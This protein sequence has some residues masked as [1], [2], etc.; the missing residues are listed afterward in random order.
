MKLPTTLLFI[1]L[2]CTNCS[3]LLLEEIEIVSPEL[4]EYWGNQVLILN[5][6][7]IGIDTSFYNDL[8]LMKFVEPTHFNKNKIVTADLFFSDSLRPSFNWIQRLNYSALKKLNR[9]SR[10]SKCIC[11][12]YRFQLKEETIPIYVPED[13]TCYPTKI[14]KELTLLNGLFIFEKDTS[15]RVLYSH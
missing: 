7:T 3:V 1:T 4:N 15:F 14:K 9:K 10:R 8:S 13:T 6:D 12:E 11:F 2:L 5:Q